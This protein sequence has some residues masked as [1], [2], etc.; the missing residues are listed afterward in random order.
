ML[1]RARPARGGSHLAY[2]MINRIKPKSEFSRS[3]LTLMAG[4]TIAQAIPVA[5]SPILTRI[6]SPQDFGVF[7]LYF[8]CV[9]VMGLI[10]TGRYEAAV[11]LPEDDQEAI[12]II[13]LAA[14]LVSITTI[15][16][17][18]VVFSFNKTIASLLNAPAIA[19][20]LYLVP[21]SVCLS[22]LYQILIVWFNRRR[23]YKTLANNKMIQSSMNGGAQ[24][25]FG[26]TIG[27]HS[28]LIIG[29][30]VAQVFS[31]LVFLR[32]CKGINVLPI[33]KNNIRY[34]LQ[35]YV[36]FPKYELPTALLNTMS[37]QGLIVAITNIF[38]TTIAGYY[39]LVER[40][41]GVSMGLI[42]SSVAQVFYQQFASCAANRTAAKRMLKKTWLSLF[43]IGIVPFSV[44][45]IF[46]PAIF[47]LIFGPSWREAGLMA[48]IL[49]PLYLLTF[50]SSPTSTAFRVLGLL[51]YALF[52]GLYVFLTRFLAVIIGYYFRSFYVGLY[53]LV[54]FEVFQ[55][56]GY[57]VLIW[58]EVCR[59]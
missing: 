55:L 27:N 40:V 35:K 9:S 12:H 48:S 6:Y 39:A 8:A 2:K 21:A 22:G 43:A 1:P 57:N 30:F 11:M 14:L 42:G 24:I 44:L 25:V 33:S 34:V 38:T 53:F 58:R 5:I 28:G 16:L 32:S 26:T 54:G 15:I 59:K 45:F 3:V 46:G 51:K 50:I 52:F 13:A 47:N 56:V 31:V 4:T 20:W 17:I 19:P 49:A 36:S 7:A 29:Y 10:A 37:K 41:L 23:K 18:I